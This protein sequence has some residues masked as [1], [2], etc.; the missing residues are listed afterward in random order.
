MRVD[1]VEAL[2]NTYQ[3]IRRNFD[4]IVDIDKVALKRFGN[5]RNENLLA[6]CMEFFGVHME[7]VCSHG[8]L[9][10]MP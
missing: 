6:Q 7:L 9:N 1:I 5:K 2:P 10:S 8:T 4:D 3:L